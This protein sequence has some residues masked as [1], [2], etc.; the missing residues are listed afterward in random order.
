MSPWHYVAPHRRTCKRDYSKAANAA[1]SAETIAVRAPQSAH[2]TAQAL[3]WLAN[4]ASRRERS[5]SIPL[6]HRRPKSRLGVVQTRRC[7]GK[8]RGLQSRDEYGFYLSEGARNVPAAGLAS[9]PRILAW[10]VEQDHSAICLRRSIG[11]R[12]AMLVSV[13]VGVKSF[14]INSLNGSSFS[15]LLGGSAPAGTLREVRLRFGGASASG[16]AVELE[17]R[18]RD[19]A[20]PPLCCVAAARLEPRRPWTVC[21]LG[22]CSCLVDCFCKPAPPS[23][24][25]LSARMPP[26]CAAALLPPA[27]S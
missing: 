22:H 8:R 1:C 15:K 6:S 2:A 12:L 25:R 27:L 23:A 11:R 19:A 17:E 16:V 9:R 5:S 4:S 18:R 14:P 20:W 21:F 10:G 26:D 7:S 13:R 3:A 24:G